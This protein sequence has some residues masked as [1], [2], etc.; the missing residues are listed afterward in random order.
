MKWTIYYF[1][2]VICIYTL[3]GFNY[4]HTLKIAL[5]VCEMFLRSL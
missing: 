2:L 1:V 5:R 4:I 3:K